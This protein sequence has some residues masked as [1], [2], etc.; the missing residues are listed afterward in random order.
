MT[1]D[2][3]QFCRHI[4]I[5]NNRADKTVC[6]PFRLRW[7]D[8]SYTDRPGLVWCFRHKTWEEGCCAPVAALEHDEVVAVND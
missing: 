6:N 7:P 1:G 5:I 2:R 3:S 4:A 8:G